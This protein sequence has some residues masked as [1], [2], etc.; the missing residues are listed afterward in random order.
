LLADDNADMREY[1]R[2]LLLHQGYDVIAVPDGEAALAAAREHEPDLVV[3]DVM[4]PRLDGFGLLR[5]LRA[6]PA[7]SM[8]PVILLSA[9]AGEESR[10][11]GLEGGA[12]DYLTKPFSARE[13]LARVG[14]RLELD[15]VRRETAQKLAEAARQK[16]AL[17]QF[18]ERRHRAESLDEIYAAALD[19][20]LSALRC[21]RAS[22]LLHDEAGVMRF[23]AWRGL[24]DDYRKAVEGH[25]PWKPGDPDPRPVCVPDIAAAELDESLKAVVTAEGIGALAFIPLVVKEKLGGK[26]M[27]YYDAP[28]AFDD[29]ELELTLTIAGQ[30]ALGIERMR[31]QAALRESEARARRLLE[32]HRTTLNNMGEGMYTVD[33]QG[34]V[35]Y[36]NP[37]AERLF[38]WKSEELL[39]RRIHDVTHYK[40]P[41]GSPLPIEEC[42]GFQ[43]LREG[44]V[45]R[46][47]AD[48][49]VRKDGSLFPVSYSSSPLRDQDGE[50][51]GLVIVFQDIT[52]R[53][54]IEQALRESKERLEYAVADRTRELRQ[55]NAALLRDMEERKNLEER[56]LQ[57]QKMESI[58]TLAG[59]IAHDFNNILNI[60][61]GYTFILRGF[62][63]RNKQIEESLAVINETVQ[64]GS[65]LVQQLLT[66]ARKSS[67]RLES[68]DA[69]AVVEK[70]VAVIRQTFPKTIESTSLLEADLPPILADKNQVEQAL[71]NL[72]VNARDAMTNGGKLIFRTRTV[73]GASLQ[74]LGALEDRY[75]CV[76]VSDTGTGMDE[77]VRKRI[78]EPFFTTKELGQGT[79]LGLSVVYGIVKNHNG[80]IDVE[81]R[82]MSG[83][84]FRLYFPVAAS[85]VSIK[86]P[87]AKVDTKT[88][89]AA[90][91]A[92]TV[93]LVED[94]KLMIDLLEKAFA[95]E[96][97]RVLT[98]TDG[99]KALEIYERHKQTIDAVLLDVGLPKI[100]GEDI[101]RKM[102]QE[103]PAV[104]IVISSGY[105]EPELKSKI[106]Q[107]GVK[108]F[109]QKPYL[110][111]D[112][113]KTFR[114]VMEG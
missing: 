24:S 90:S 75:V 112:V 91:G 46:D 30:L 97:Y 61:Q 39:G 45:L 20:I 43:V 81:S 95:R 41:D 99:E 88:T 98:A 53:K 9:R 36:V 77:S 94:E 65:A 35:T 55:A 109:L 38:G 47:F 66:M 59:G 27:I 17:Y 84:S 76:E 67:T 68:V 31:A 93:L 102:K 79:G 13:L 113:L 7:T 96:G 32:L 54:Q 80:L 108:H 14:S 87:V 22:I 42:A 60:I 33:V 51:A 50:I 63:A 15:R 48:T 21:E 92:A 58:G 11:E 10:V 69:N 18:V 86:D 3:A 73:A 62:G 49:F 28:H 72:C 71:L 8:L 52:E 1:V 2:R 4:M 70:L 44:R 101:L 104:K 114:S 37:E 110:P 64:R 23:V 106:D 16:E 85:E 74:G 111:D 29:E 26:F 82:P 103:N 83:A 34:L 19:A 40:R 57:A 5:A 25:S 56:L 12:D 105:L 78:F 107:A 6:D 100:A 89:G